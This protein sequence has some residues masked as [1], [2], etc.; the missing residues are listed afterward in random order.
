MKGSERTKAEE[1]VVKSNSL[2]LM[3]SLSRQRSNS[4]ISI[5]ENSFDSDGLPVSR[6]ISKS[7]GGEMD[8]SV[9]KSLPLSDRSKERH[10]YEDDVDDFEDGA[11][12]PDTKKSLESVK[13]S[14]DDVDDED[15]DLDDL[16]GRGIGKP[17]TSRPTSRLESQNR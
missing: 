14:F 16:I 17:T 6:P 7:P 8:K 4:E 10:Y 13:T 12:T 2:D 9:S 3:R 1:V 15:E 5:S 11:I